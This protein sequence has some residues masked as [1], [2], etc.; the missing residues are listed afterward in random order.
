MQSSAAKVAVPEFGLPKVPR[1]KVV[2]I[3]IVAS[4]FVPARNIDVWL[5]DDYRA[6]RRYPVLYMHDGQMLFDPTITWNKQAWNIAQVASKLIDRNEVRSF[7]VVGVFNSENRGGEYLPQKALDLLSPEQK[8]EQ[9]AAGAKNKL[10]PKADDYLRYLTQEVKPYI[11]SHFRTRSGREDTF[12]AGSSM[13]GLISMYAICEY[14]DV[15]GAAACVS[16]HWPGGGNNFSEKNLPT[17]ILTYLAAKLPDPKT[18]RLYFDHGDKTLD[19]QYGPY[20]AQA[21]RILRLKGYDATNWL[22]KVFPGDDH[23]EKSWS[24]RFDGVLKFL[25]PPKG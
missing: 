14:P 12:I 7:I 25:L 15:F 18:H 24:A 11:D 9:L 10:M 13:G 16:T 19:A 5:P 6:G 2:R 22:T 8:Q 1:G 20:Q 17:A 4:Q 23:T 21:D 3:P